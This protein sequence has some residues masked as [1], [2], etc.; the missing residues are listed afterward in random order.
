[1]VLVRGFL[2]AEEV[3]HREQA[4]WAEALRA[5]G[6]RGSIYALWWDAFRPADVLSRLSISTMGKISWMLNPLRAALPLAFEGSAS[7]AKAAHDLLREAEGR[8]DEVATGHFSDLMNRVDSKKVSFLGFSLGARVVLGGL[9]NWTPPRG[10][11]VTDIMLAA[12]AVPTAGEALRSFIET[13]R[14]SR[15][16]PA[17]SPLGPVEGP[18]LCH[19]SARVVNLYSTNDFV[20]TDMFSLSNGTIFEALGTRPLHH[21]RVTNVHVNTRRFRAEGLFDYAMMVANACMEHERAYHETLQG[22]R[23]GDFIEDRGTGPTDRSPNGRWWR[24]PGT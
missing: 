7:L 4:A 21:S 12:A 20:L 11:C 10:S 23:Q 17:D 19:D 16:Q 1:M 13:V 14:I 3:S 22:R 8:A 24:S 9:A 15:G 18:L 6:W 2:S 5:S